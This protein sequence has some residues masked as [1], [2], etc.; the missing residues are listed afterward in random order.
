[1]TTRLRQ[2]HARLCE[3]RE[4]FFALPE[5][6]RAD[7]VHDAPIRAEIQ[8]L[9]AEADT[10]LPEPALP[11]GFRFGFPHY[12]EEV[13]AYGFRI[14]PDAGSPPESW[15]AIV[16]FEDAATVLAPY[17]LAITPAMGGDF[18]LRGTD[19]SAARRE[20]LLGPPDQ[21]EVI[22]YVFLCPEGVSR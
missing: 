20:R 8:K 9:F 22:A 1:M 11:A 12:G 7:N 16:T 15:G 10:L 21:Q 5:S 6:Q 18:F 17:G 2:I 19:G 14:L 13:V 3:L 4:A